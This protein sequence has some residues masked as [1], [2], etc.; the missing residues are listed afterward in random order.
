[1]QSLHNQ[2]E[3]WR[4][5]ARLI[6]ASLRRGSSTRQTRGEGDKS[7]RAQEGRQAHWI[8]CAKVSGGW[9]ES[10]CSSPVVLLL[11]WEGPGD[12]ESVDFAHRDDCKGTQIGK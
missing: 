7:R 9:R 5:S 10:D 3:T 2:P 1:M 8:Y 11:R 12:V 4:I 6:L